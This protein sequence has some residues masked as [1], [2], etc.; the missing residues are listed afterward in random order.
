MRQGGCNLIDSIASL[1]LYIIRVIRPFLAIIIVYSCYS[2]MRR[3]I[4]EDKP[5]IVLYNT[6]TKEDIPVIYWE[7][8]IGRSKNSDIVLSD[9]S[10]S[11][12]HAV[13]LRREEGWF[14]TDT[15]SKSGIVVNGN[16]IHSRAPVYL[17]DV[18]TIGST[19]LILKKHK[20]EN[21]SNA[22]R[23]FNKNRVPKAAPAF[24]LLILVTI[25]HL[26]N[27][28]EL[29][30][31]NQRF[32]YE[33][34]IPF[35]ILIGMSFL[36]LGISRFVFKRINF[37]LEA[38]GIF[39]SGIGIA[40]ICSD[41]VSNTYI[42]LISIAIGMIVFCAI[43]KFIENPDRATKWRFV[44]SAGA[45]LL[46]V[47]NIL[48]GTV[49]NGSQNWIILGPV[50]IQPSEFVKIAFIFVGA[51][52]LDKLQTTKNLTEFIIF[53]SLCIGA[54]FIINDFGTACIFFVTFLIIAFMRSGDLK[55]I[56]LI[57][58][59]ALLGMFM[60]LKFKPYV[61]D[62]FLSWGKAYEYADTFGYQQSR[63]LTYSASGGLFGVGVGLGDLKYVFAATS[64]LVF[65]MICEEMGLIMGII[66]AMTILWFA[67]YARR[68]SYRSR[69]TF[70]Y[71][72][73]CS[74]AGLL[75]FQMCLNVFG[76]TDILPLTGVTLPFISLGGSSIISVFAMLAFI[77]ASDERTY[78]IRNL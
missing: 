44:I 56:I 52:T 20:Q 60:I 66:V 41:D 27:A 10:V 49:Q 21:Q 3:N 59:A 19:S 38:L 32:N 25:F 16:R 74:A 75:V 39:L 67:V 45:V 63:V 35:G 43:I 54:L 15:G 68:V 7:N 78:A 22:A 76:A 13:L 72:S 26:M 9:P 51:S 62:R 55:T 24:G 11:R 46:L 18:I 50:S 4:R 2:S 53:S 40:M 37:E 36:F 71:I 73:S 23:V 61:A 48:V 64:D 33:P 14:I 1:V 30:T 31:I 28:F 65:G 29:C 12:D 47:L 69:S 70:Y 58:A 77:K 57:C 8:S 5:L 34:L 6:L 17:D 42:Q